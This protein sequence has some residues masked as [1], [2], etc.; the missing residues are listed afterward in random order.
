MIKRAIL[1]GLE[2]ELKS[3]K[4]IVLTGM[5]RVGKTTLVRYLYDRIAEHRKLFLDLENPLH[6]QL[7]SQV[8]YGAIKDTLNQLAEGRGERF[9]VVLDEIQSVKTIPSV[10]KYLADHYRVKFIV[11]GSASFYLK[12]LF[13]E[14]LAGRKRIFELFPLDIAEFI[15]APVT[16]MR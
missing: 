15:A 8:D 5:R 13:S 16:S 12:N 4:V 14:S 11:T 3:D 1:A 7:F 2:E 6:Q 10:V 9:V